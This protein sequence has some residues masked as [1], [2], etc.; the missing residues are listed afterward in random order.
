V[1]LSDQLTAYQ[2]AVPEA[3]QAALCVFVKTKEPR[4]DW[5]VSRRTGDQL[6][7]FLRK[8]DYVAREIS[9]RHFFKRPGD[10]C[11][12]CDYLPVCLG[13]ERKVRETLVF[14]S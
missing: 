7:E 11:A 14:L 6:S 13:D 5:Y 8:A 3:E 10:W 2:L 9:A 12:W 1:A 4:I